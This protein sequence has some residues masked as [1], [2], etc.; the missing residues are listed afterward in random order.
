MD[1]YD[2][3]WTKSN[4][5]EC[6]CGCWKTYGKECNKEFHSDWCELSPNFVKNDENKNINMFGVTYD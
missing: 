3:M 4:K 1:Y 6:T 2:N 5:A